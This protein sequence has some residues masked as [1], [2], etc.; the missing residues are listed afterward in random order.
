ME[1]TF[2][3]LSHEE[4]SKQ[5]PDFVIFNKN[6]V[7]PTVTL[8]V[9]KTMTEKVQMKTENEVLFAL[10]RVIFRRMT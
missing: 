9:F 7:S 8:G 10:V 1:T 2:C 3:S 6:D 5:Y 4:S